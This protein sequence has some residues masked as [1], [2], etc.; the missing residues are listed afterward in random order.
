MKIFEENGMIRFQLMD[1]NKG[2]MLFD[3]KVEKEAFPIL[4][5]HI[6]EHLK[7]FKIK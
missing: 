4:K 3:F 5:D 7:A 6:I 2:S 1:M